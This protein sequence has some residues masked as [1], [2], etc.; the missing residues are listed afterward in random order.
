LLISVQ[1]VLAKLT[2]QLCGLCGGLSE[3]ATRSGLN[4]YITA[5]YAANAASEIAGT[6]FA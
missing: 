4:P 5:V 6:A 2:D 3:D 1:R